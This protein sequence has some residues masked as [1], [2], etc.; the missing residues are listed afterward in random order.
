MLYLKSLRPAISLLA[1]ILVLVAFVNAKWTNYALLIALGV[2]FASGATM[3]QND[4]H[5]RYHDSKKGKSFVLENEKMF[6]IFVLLIWVICLI[7]AVAISYINYVHGIIYVNVLIIGAAYSE[8]LLVPF[9]PNFLVA[10]A[11]AVSTLY[12]LDRFHFVNSSLLFLLVLLIISLR[13]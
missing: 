4:Y 2:F 8:L 13:E 12:A 10:F 11:S 5:D 7:F 9:L 3:A 1:A 6:K